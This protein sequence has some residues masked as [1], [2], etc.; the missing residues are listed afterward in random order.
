MSTT[1]PAG[2]YPDP[3]PIDPAHP[4]QRWWN[5][6]EWTVSTKPDEVLTIGP[7]PTKRARPRRATVLAGT[8]AALL[9]LGVGSLTTYLIMDGR[10][11]TT[12]SSPSPS[13]RFNQGG[14][15]FGEGGSG[16]S[17]GGSGGT[18]GGS[19][20][21]GG[22]GGAPGG[23]G[24]SSGGS[25]GL[26]GA[27]STTAYDVVDGLSLPIPSGWTG[28]T[29]DDGHAGLAIGQYTCAQSS[30]ST[31]TLGGAN[32]ETLKASVG[33]GAE[34]AAKADI[35]GAVKE[36]YGDITGHQQLESQAVTVAGRS[37]YL[38]RWKIDAKV[39]NSGTVET[40]VFPTSD[41]KSLVALHM[42]FDTAAKA[43]D[44]SLMDTIVSG[45]KDADTA[46]L[47]GGGTGS[48]GS[49]S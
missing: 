42:G 22:S 41:N 3:K 45:I 15:P 30:S 31:C 6:S 20:G 11:S 5:G 9:G 46:N 29:T 24:G 28:G 13:Q 37:G 32:T 35:A 36:A 17:G 18:G 23:S 25:G 10:H 33:D 49:N 16:G 38:I 40:V 4:G 34:A 8:V 39:G 14:A 2:W 26:G 48:T 47:S 44:V 12:T 1:T 27:S 21:T 19:G 43:P 7:V